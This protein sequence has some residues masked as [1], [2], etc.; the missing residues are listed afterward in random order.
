MAQNKEQYTTLDY[1]K[2]EDIISRYYDPDKY[3]SDQKYICRFPPMKEANFQFTHF[4]L[5]DGSE[6]YP[7]YIFDVT[8]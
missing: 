1:N 2:Y 7:P 8:L 3:T 4:T 5:V 6:A